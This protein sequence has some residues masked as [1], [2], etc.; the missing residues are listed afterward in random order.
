MEANIK[1]IKQQME[2]LMVSSFLTKSISR[3]YYKIFKPHE[4]VWMGYGD[5][6]FSLIQYY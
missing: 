1:Y 5:H 6:C 3:K 4:V 2:A